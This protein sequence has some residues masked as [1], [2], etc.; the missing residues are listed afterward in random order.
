MGEFNGEEVIIAIQ[1]N[2][3]I[4]WR[5][6]VMDQNFRSEGKIKIRYN[7][8]CNQFQNNPRYIIADPNISDYSL[9]DDENIQYEITVHDKQYQASYLQNPD[10]PGYLD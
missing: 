3:N 5:I 7:N 8:L 10:I 4:V 1:T 6:N 9:P 2:N